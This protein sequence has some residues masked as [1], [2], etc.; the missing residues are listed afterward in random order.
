MIFETTESICGFFFK[1]AYVVF[2]LRCKIPHL[3]CP[4]IDFE[5][6]GSIITLLNLE[7]LKRG[8]YFV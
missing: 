2:G 8:L 4:R 3:V 5:R 1:I 7:R 6:V